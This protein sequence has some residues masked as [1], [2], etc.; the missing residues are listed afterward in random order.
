[1]KEYIPPIIW[2]PALAVT[3]VV[4]ILILALIPP[5]WSGGT[6]ERLAAVIQRIE[7]AVDE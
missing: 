4:A 1:M 6:L 2:L 7:D 5:K 3:W